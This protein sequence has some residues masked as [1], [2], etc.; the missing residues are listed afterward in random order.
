MTWSQKLRCGQVRGTSAGLDR[1]V[2]DNNVGK[3]TDDE[4]NHLETL[5]PLRPL[6]PHRSICVTE[7]QMNRLTIFNFANYI[8]L[9]MSAALASFVR[10]CVC[11]LCDKVLLPPFHSLRNLQVLFHFRCVAAANRFIAFIR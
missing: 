3:A 6:P 8:F 1:I 4:E 9:L 2:D 5:Q 11:R 7:T 10:V